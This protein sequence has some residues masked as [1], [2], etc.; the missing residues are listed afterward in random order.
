MGKNIADQRGTGIKDC[1]NFMHP[2]CTHVL[3]LSVYE[4]IASN[5]AQDLTMTLSL[6]MTALVQNAHP[7]V[8]STSLLSHLVSESTY[9]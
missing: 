5:L 7:D 9:L 4:E 1:S 6:S 8:T 2:Y 3:S